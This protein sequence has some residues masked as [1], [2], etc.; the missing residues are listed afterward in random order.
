[1]RVNHP[2]KERAQLAPLLLQAGAVYFQ[3]P[4]GYPMGCRLLV[5]DIYPPSRIPRPWGSF[6]VG[7][8]R[9]PMSA[10]RMS[11]KTVPGGRRA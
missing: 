6:W 1:M 11:P 10:P 7:L 2:Q 3:I 4:I 9:H 8:G 5:A